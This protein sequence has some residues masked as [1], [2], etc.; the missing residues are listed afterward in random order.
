MHV[1]LILLSPSQ[2]SITVANSKNWRE[3]LECNFPIEDLLTQL[4]GKCIL[5]V[6]ETE[7]IQSTSNH[8]EKNRRFFK[9]LCRKDENV[10]LKG[11]LAILSQ[12]QY[13]SYHYLGDMLEDL[14]R[15]QR[16]DSS[17]SQVSMSRSRVLILS[18]CIHMW[19]YTIQY[20]PM[21]ILL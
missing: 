14:F 12:P 20:I 2:D 15:T 18:A 11:T 17:L 19:L 16:S 10:A 13:K 5:T 21:Y 7:E 4:Q 1:Y 8:V 9:F 3:M 6:Y